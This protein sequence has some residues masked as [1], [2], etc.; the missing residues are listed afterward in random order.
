MSNRISTASPPV[1][2]PP[3]PASA[4]ALALAAAF[5]HAL[6]NMLLARARDS[7]AAAAVALAIGVV[8][9]APA[10]A[11]TWRVESAVIPYAIAS[12]TLEIVYFV[13]LAAAYESG[14]L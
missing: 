11:I 14:E 5:V 13:F 9:F 6:W 7:Q 1:C 4:L 3:M 10:A 12:S 2:R 8:A